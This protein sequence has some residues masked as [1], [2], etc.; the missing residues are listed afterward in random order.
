MTDP[1]VRAGAD[2]GAAGCGVR[3]WRQEAAM[4]PPVSTQCPDHLF[5]RV[6]REVINEILM[7]LFDQLMPPLVPP[8]P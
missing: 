4:V 1:G 8:G 6:R 3:D 5:D 7:Q 2:I